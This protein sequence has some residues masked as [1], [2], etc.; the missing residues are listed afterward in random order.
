LGTD[1]AS[2]LSRAGHALAYVVHDFDAGAHFLDR[3]LMLNP[4][5]ATAWS[6]SGWLK[7]WT[8]E[9]EVA[10]R[11]FAH[12]KRFSPFDPLMPL[13]QS[14]S[15]FAYFFA[16]RYDEAASLADQVL[17]EAPSLHQAL[18][19]SAAANALARRIERAQKTLARLRQIDP[20]LR[21]SNLADLTPLQRPEDMARYA[22]GMR[23]AGLPE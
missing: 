3:A 21:V 18:R 11:H 17:Q 20:A 12:F 23:K 8:G 2:T 22:E 1:D 15:A 13:A 9:P 14:G 5:L 4:N 10:I 19:I 7:I 6:S 16:G